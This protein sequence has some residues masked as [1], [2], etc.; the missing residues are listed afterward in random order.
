MSTEIRAL[1]PDDVE[2]FRDL[3]LAALQG[4]PE[5]FGSS[6][7]LERERPLAQ[8]AERLGAEND[9]LVVGALQ[10]GA[11][12]GMAGFYRDSHTKMQHRGHVWGMFVRPAARG[13][14]LGGSLLDALVAHAAALDGLLQVNLE[15]VSSNGAALA[16]YEGRGFQRFGL[17]RRALIV[18]GQALDEVLMVLPLAPFQAARAG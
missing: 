17:E 16:L 10:A 8:F 15:V 6:Y 5:A 4:S 14:G 3:R 11:L 7:D 1:S 2:G 13:Q 12:V 18:E 9:G